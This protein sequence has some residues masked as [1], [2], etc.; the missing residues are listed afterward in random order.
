M[1]T[2]TARTLCFATLLP[3]LFGAASALQAQQPNAREA[4]ALQAARSFGEALARG[5]SVAMLALLHDDVVI[6]EGGHAETKAQ[7]RTGHI[8]SDIAYATAVKSERVK[9]AVL[10]SG[11]VALYTRESRARGRYRD[12]DVDSVGTETMVLVR[13]PEGWKIRHIH[14]SSGRP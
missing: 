12:R 4:E 2:M 11:D 5:D 7:Y 6:Y 10:L 14:W 3:L 8:R 13:T 1:R 9:D